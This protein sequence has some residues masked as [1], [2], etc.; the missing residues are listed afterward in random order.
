MKYYDIELIDVSEN[1][2]NFKFHK[3]NKKELEKITTFFKEDKPYLEFTAEEG[4]VVLKTAHI[5]GV[6]YQEYEEKEKTVLQENMESAE[7]ISKIKLKKTVF[8]T[9]SGAIIC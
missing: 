9:T 3:I 8:N 6:M 4:S 7:E 2:D 1:I 5:R